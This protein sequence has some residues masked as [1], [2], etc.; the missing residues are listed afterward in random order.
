MISKALGCAR[1]QNFTIALA[2]LESENS[3]SEFITKEYFYWAHSSETLILALRKHFGLS[4]EAE[5]G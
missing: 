1:E 3:L 5:L 4:I 2:N